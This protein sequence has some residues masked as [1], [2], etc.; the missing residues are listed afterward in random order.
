MFYCLLESPVGNILIA[1]DKRGLKLINFQDGPNAQ[2]PDPKWKEDSQFFRAVI[3]QFH[4][5]FGGRLTQFR[6]PLAPE[7]TP[8]Q[9]KVWKAL[10]RIPYGKTVSYGEIARRI[11]NPKASRA[12]GAANGQNPLSIIVPCHRVIG[13]TGDLVGYG[14]G[15]TIK[16]TLLEHERRRVESFF[17]D[18]SSA[19]QTTSLS[20]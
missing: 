17:T 11:G 20:S 9:M 19:G 18:L 10:Q 5:Y 4:A 8:F 12:V 3:Q 1:G 15:L 7:G 2:A 14:G 16:K 13:Q 6:V